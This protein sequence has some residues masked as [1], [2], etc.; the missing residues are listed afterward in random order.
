[1]TTS[2]LSTP[3]YV[4][5]TTLQTQDKLVLYQIAQYGTISSTFHRPETALP[6]LYSPKKNTLY[7]THTEQAT[8]KDTR[9]KPPEK[10]RHAIVVIRR[11]K[12]RDGIALTSSRSL[13]RQDGVQA[14]QLHSSG[15]QSDGVVGILN[16]PLEAVANHP[17]RSGVLFGLPS[18]F[19]GR[20]AF[21]F[22]Q[23]EEQR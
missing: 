13:S 23:R 10:I 6:T 15:V 9:A 14:Q 3:Q 21:E 2:S 20:A 8:R 1:M 4:E 12:Q 17:P 11:S 22:A 7:L 5:G 19:G 16:A 18:P